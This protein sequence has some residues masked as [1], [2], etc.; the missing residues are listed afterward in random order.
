MKQQKNKK[1]SLETYSVLIDTAPV[2]AKKN[3]IREGELK[4]KINRETVERNAIYKIGDYVELNSGTELLLGGLFGYEYNEGTLPTVLYFAEGFPTTSI[5]ES[6]I[7]GL[8]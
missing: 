5:K 1:V 3:N 8:K 4:H 2:V 6:E 7:K